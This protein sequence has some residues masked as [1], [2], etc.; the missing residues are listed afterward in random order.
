MNTPTNSETLPPTP[1]S[2]F[3]IV[4]V[5]DRPDEKGIAERRANGYLYYVHPSLRD[6]KKYWAMNPD[7]PTPLEDFGIRWTI[8]SGQFRGNL[9]DQSRATY[10]D[11]RTRKWQGDDEFSFPLQNA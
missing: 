11:G 1:G 5:Y 9:V 10:G 3:F 2:G 7:N 8:E 6:E 4:N